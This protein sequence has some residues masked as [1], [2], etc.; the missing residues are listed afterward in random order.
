M[1]TFTPKKNLKYQANFLVRPS[2]KH[3]YITKFGDFIGFITE[4]VIKYYKDM[5]ES[6]NYITRLKL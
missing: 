1:P 5:L 4:V 2:V 6:P 3:Q